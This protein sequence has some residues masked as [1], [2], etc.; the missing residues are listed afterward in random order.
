[1]KWLHP[2]TIV[3]S[4]EGR[5]ESMSASLRF[6]QDSNI[7]VQ[8]RMA[9]LVSV[10]KMARESVGISNQL[11]SF[12]SA[13]SPLSKYLLMLQVVSCVSQALPNTY[14]FLD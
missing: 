11:K 6:G 14:V 5:R 13:T 10:E 2:K 1:M 4:P 12:P 8:T 9:V 7:H 3:T